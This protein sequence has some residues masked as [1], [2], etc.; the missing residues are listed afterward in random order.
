MRINKLQAKKLHEKWTIN[1]D[2][3]ATYL[4]FRRTI[5]PSYD[6]DIMVHWCNMW[7]CILARDGSS[8]S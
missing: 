8:H 4:H 6:G 5:H 3:H 2:G 7:L 1:P